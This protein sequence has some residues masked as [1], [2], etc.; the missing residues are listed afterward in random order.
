MRNTH[1]NRPVKNIGRSKGGGGLGGASSG[2]A[3]GGASKVGGGGGASRSGGGSGAS[4]SGGSGRTEN[5]HMAMATTALD[6]GF[7]WAGEHLLSVC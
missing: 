6:F 4:S 3:S 2:G 5:G 1:V 7:N